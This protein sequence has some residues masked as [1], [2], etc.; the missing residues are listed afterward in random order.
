MAS[1]TLALT[2]DH[3]QPRVVRDRIA[4]LISGKY[5]PALVSGKAASGW[6]QTYGTK[7]ANDDLLT[8]VDPVTGTLMLTPAPL[9]AAW[10]QNRSGIYARLTTT[11]YTGLTG[12]HWKDHQADGANSNYVTSDG[13]TEA[14]VTTATYAKNRGFYISWYNYSFGNDNEVYLEC[15]WN[16]SASS[17]SGVSL[18]IF[19]NGRIEV[20]KNGLL[21]SKA[22][23]TITG[24][25]PSADRKYVSLLLI[26]F[27]KRELLV[28]DIRAQDGFSHVFDDIDEDDEDPTITDATNFWWNVPKGNASVECAPLQFPASAYRPSYVVYFGTPPPAGQDPTITVYSTNGTA[29]GSM[30]QSTDPTTTFTADGTTAKARLRVDL[31]AGSSQTQT[32]FVYGVLGEWP[33]DIGYTD[34]SE[35]TLLED[36]TLSA[37]LEAPESPDGMRLQITLKSPDEID[38][39]Q[40]AGLLTVSNRPI[41]A[42]VGNDTD[43][44]VPLFDGVTMPVPWSESTSDATRR[45][46]MEARGLWRLLENYHFSEATPLDGLTITEAFKF[47]CTSAGIPEDR[48][49][50]E[51]DPTTLP[52]ANG[53]RGDWS[54][55][56]NIYDTPAEW[57][58]RLKDAYVG[59]WFIG[60]VPTEDGVTKLKFASPEGLGD[61]SKFTLFD[62]YQDAYDQLVLEGYS[63]GDAA[64]LSFQRWAQTIKYSSLEPEAN[65]V[66]V[67]GLDPRTFLP[68][69]ARYKD[70][71][72][73]DPTLPPSARPDNWLGEIRKAGYGQKILSTQ[74]AV[75]AACTLLASRLT[76]RRYL[77]EFSCEMMFDAS[78]GLPIWRGDVVTLPDGNDYRIVSLSVTWDVEDPDTAN[79]S[80]NVR[81]AT[82]VAEKLVE[83][84]SKGCGFKTT[85]TSIDTIRASHMLGVVQ[86]QRMK[87][88]G[89]FGQRPVVASTLLP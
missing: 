86:Y 27:R 38:P 83:G 76:V 28:Y 80:A 79:G 12:S 4:A 88:F 25:N 10:N 85:G 78:T 74:T 71:D 26:P 60:E 87:N 84:T 53:S 67:M 1:K 22:N 70:T 48:L 59:T 49:D 54:T 32:P 3:E 5:E 34:A 40:I 15:G 89:D 50:V 39:G 36:Y 66:W 56:I 37:R 61:A 2:L 42:Q 31:T 21:V 62:N 33:A 68:I 20:Y 52:I 47:L 41:I 45:V 75:N 55:L 64:Q 18:K 29:T 46:Q 81:T 51:D 82:Y 43:G 30:V 13:T 73:Q 6:S 58:G 17:A 14:A 23:Q 63:A 35:E 8:W 16:S 24:N 65:E 19:I 57:I 44:Y 9:L 7:D 11:D 77:A 72:S 69:V